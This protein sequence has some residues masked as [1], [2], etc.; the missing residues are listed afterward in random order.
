MAETIPAERPASKQ[1]VERV[2]RAGARLIA[3]L[4]K[5]AAFSAR[6]CHHP[7][8]EYLFLE[9]ACA[10]GEVEI[11]RAEYEASLSEAGFPDIPIR[12]LIEPS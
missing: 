3:A 8:D 4:S 10:R 2:N 5:E 9:W 11:C 1:I 7:Q 6:C 12:K